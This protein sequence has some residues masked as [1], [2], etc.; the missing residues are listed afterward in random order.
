MPIQ[1]ISFPNLS[2]DEANPFLKGISKGQEL[3]QNF[4]MFPEELKQKILGNALQNF[5]VQQEENRSQYY[6]R[7]NIAE[8]LKSEAEPREIAARTG[9]YGAQAN[10][11][12]TLTP[13]EAEE[14]KLKNKF[15]PDLIRSQIESSHALS[16][17][18]NMGGSNLGVGQKQLF[19]F[20]QQLLRDNP[21][22]SEDQINQAAN[23]YL[24][25]LDKFPD[26]TP[27]PPLSGQSKAFVDQIIKQGTTAPI[28]TG[29]IR[30]NQAEAE[31]EVLS[32]YASKG[33]EPYGNTYF[34]ISPKQISDT[35]K[36]D[37]ESQKR[38]G[39]FAAS[40]ALQYEVAQN[41]IRLANGQP[42]V[43][44]TEELIKLSA[45]QVKGKYPKL[46]NKARE[47]A[48]R[49]LDEALREGLTARKSIG[50]G[51]SD[52]L[53]NRSEKIT[54]SGI[55]ALSKG[56]KYPKFESKEEFQSWFKRQPSIVQ[57]A[58]SADLSK[59]SK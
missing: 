38:L 34:N 23:S 49:Y 29:N 12:N 40:Q 28:L 15:Y 56:I 13:L 20:R 39:R 37:E 3:A 7:L 6:P 31:L 8:V 44:S 2:F 47:E 43:N 35:F 52:N 45:Q 27:L 46:S 33:L 41:R 17:L 30:A 10:R 48:S 42:G 16:N 19:G 21:D 18:R 55:N 5:K 53:N 14:A 50:I 26:G 32:D 24:S 22:W 51:A 58:I 57:K 59:R 54:N 11:F 1:P 4:L 25:G 9:L 36:T